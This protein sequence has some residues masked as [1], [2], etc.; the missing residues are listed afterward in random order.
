MRRETESEQTGPPADYVAWF[1]EN[2]FLDVLSTEVVTVGGLE[3]TR[4]EVQNNGE[5]FPLIKLSDGSDYDFSYL[6]HIYAH[7]LDANG[8]QI[9]ISCGVSGGSNFAAF[10][11]QCDEVLETV[12]FGR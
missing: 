4:L 8:S 12:D 1:N 2:P 7:I 9:I 5:P 3:G 10:A 11:E 6:D